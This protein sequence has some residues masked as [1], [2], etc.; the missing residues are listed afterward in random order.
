MYLS[1]ACVHDCVRVYVPMKESK[2]FYHLLF[3]TDDFELLDRWSSRIAATKTCCCSIPSAQTRPNARSSPRPLL[4]A[5][6]KGLGP[7]PARPTMADWINTKKEKLYI[8]DAV[9]IQHEEILEP[10]IHCC[11]TFLVSA[12]LVARPAHS[13]VRQ[14]QRDLNWKK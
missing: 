13:H 11:C 6:S 9:F 8:S 10:I 1:P 7:R 14:I 3:K 12:S 2:T 5:Y 4:R